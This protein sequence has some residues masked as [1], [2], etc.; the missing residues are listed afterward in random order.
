MGRFLQ[1][2]RNSNEIPVFNKNHNF[3]AEDENY[4]LSLLPSISV[5]TNDMNFGSTDR[6]IL[7][8]EF[9]ELS[10]TADLLKG[11]SGSMDINQS[12]GMSGLSDINDLMPPPIMLPSHLGS[13]SNALDSG[14]T[15]GEGIAYAFPTRTLPKK[16]PSLYMSP[17]RMPL[18]KAATLNHA[19]LE[20]KKMVKEKSLTSAAALNE[21]GMIQ[22]APTGQPTEE[23]TNQSQSVSDISTVP[24]GSLGSSSTSS[25]A[26]MHVSGGSGNE[27]TSPPQHYNSGVKNSTSNPKKPHRSSKSLS[28]IDSASGDPSAF[29]ALLQ[30]FRNRSD[31]QRSLNS[32]SWSIN[33]GISSMSIGDLTRSSDTAPHQ[34]V[35]GSKN[36]PR[37][38][39]L[40]T[41]DSRDEM[42]ESTTDK[43]TGAP[44]AAAAAVGTRATKNSESHSGGGA[45]H[46]SHAAAHGGHHNANSHI[47]HHHVKE[48][49]HGSAQKQKLKR[50][51]I[52][53]RQDGLSPTN[54]DATSSS[55]LDTSSNAAAAPFQ[56]Q[57]QQMQAPLMGGA[58]PVTTMGADNTPYTTYYVPVSGAGAV[59]SSVYP[60]AMDPNC[61]PCA[62]PSPEYQYSNSNGG[63]P[64]NCFPG[65]LSV[66]SESYSYNAG[67]PGY[68]AMDDS[69]ISAAMNSLSY[70]RSNSSS[71][72]GEHLSN[73]ALNSYVSN[74]NSAGAGYYSVPNGSISFNNFNPNPMASSN[75]LSYLAEI[76]GENNLFKEKPKPQRY[77]GRSNYRC[78]KCGMPKVRN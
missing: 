45:L 12:I 27:Q 28:Q 17:A 21:F 78:G 47:V 57:Q 7:R 32:S 59:A 11:L 41:A 53:K 40:L 15:H 76:K 20:H 64:R 16:S 52:L 67:M 71:S 25:G 13:S 37:L 35:K 50:H 36:Y 19:M 68:S 23:V 10:D 58:V 1:D 2:R 5:D 60:S 38:V 61:M 54:R 43:T 26:A 74:F 39:Q 3:S 70:G 49:H 62:M 8:R 24:S 4:L 6:S 34:H 46:N 73:P 75:T 30:H 65:S 42:E 18:S 14:R 77:V 51:E 31:S 29:D 44:N 63:T 66:T 69:S 22:V 55:W 56:A 9:S 33:S 48:S 72:G